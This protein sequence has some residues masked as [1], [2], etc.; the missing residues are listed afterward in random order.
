MKSDIVSAVTSDLSIPFAE[1]MQAM[2]A[3][4]RF[5]RQNARKEV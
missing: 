2:M 3:S 4:G 5:G 1:R